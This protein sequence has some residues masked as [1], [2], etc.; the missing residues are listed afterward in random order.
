MKSF[1]LSKSTYCS[2]VQCPKI[3]WLNQNNPEVATASN[4]DSILETGLEVGELAKGL[5]GEY[6]NI[7]SENGLA[8]MLNDT[9]EALESGINIITEASFAD[10]NNFCSVDILKNNPEGLDIYEVKSS[11][12]I[13]DIHLHDLAYQYYVLTSLGY[14]INS[15]NLI[16]INNGY[17][18]QGELDLTQLFTIENKTE[19]IIEM[20]SDVKLRIEAISEYMKR[21]DEPAKDLGLYCFDPY[22][23]PY[24]SY[25][26]KHLPKKNVFDL[27]GMLKKEKFKYYYEGIYSYE[28]LSVSPL[29]LK[30]LEQVLYELDNRAPKIELDEIKIFLNNLYYPLYFLDF[31]TFQQAIPAYDGISPYM[32]IPFQYSLHYIEKE[33]GELKHRE[34]LAPVGVDPRS[35]LA[36]QLVRDIPTDACVL[37]YNMGFEKGVIRNL[38]KLYPNLATN[39]LMIHD[40]IQ[41][42]MVPFQKRH[43]YAKEMSGSY[44]IKKV[45][46]TLFPDDPQLN[47]HEL[48]LI[49]NGSEAMSAFAQLKDKSPEEIAAIRTALLAYCKLDTL[50]MVKIWQKLIE[51]S[52]KELIYC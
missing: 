32:Q 6:H 40:N 48:N 42:L 1:K 44:S 17:V 46:P 7:D 36:N 49:H 18:R 20:Q 38:A 50:A 39:L 9:E 29:K 15:A 25:C 11:T 26:A 14:Q 52:S 21:T 35:D 47:Y 30:Y 10:Q 22:D 33:G 31:E 28:D 8:G 34:F 37:A 23:C 16:Y 51:I 27:A 19:T 5:F 41:D 3:L 2:G 45:L 4:N 43:Y 12:E 24:W 13:K